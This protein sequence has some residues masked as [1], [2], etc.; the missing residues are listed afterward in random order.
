M[1]TANRSAVALVATAVLISLFQPAIQAATKEDFGQLNVRREHMAWPSP[2]SIVRDLRSQDDGVRFKALLLLGVSEERARIRV[3]SH[4]TPSVVTGSEVVKPEQI[5]LRY[6]A[7]GRDETQQAIVAAQYVGDS[8]IAA[9]AAPKPNGTGWERIAIFDCWCKYDAA[10]MLDEFVSLRQALEP[11]PHF[12]RMRQR[13]Y[14]LDRAVVGAI[15]SRP[16]KLRA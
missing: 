4:T 7:L 13:N 12:E 16:P 14:R 11:N 10:G 5:E 9:V 3:W 1:L 6:A 2:A 8:A 15:C